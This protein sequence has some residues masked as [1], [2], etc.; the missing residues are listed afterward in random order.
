MFRF[1]DLITALSDKSKDSGLEFEAFDARGKE[2]D[3][4]DV[5][6]YMNKGVHEIGLYI[7]N[8]FIPGIRVYLTNT[9]MQ[10]DLARMPIKYGE[11]ISCFDETI[12]LGSFWNRTRY[13]VQD[14]VIPVQNLDP[15]ML[16]KYVVQIHPFANFDSPH[17]V[18]TVSDTIEMISICYPDMDKR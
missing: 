14:K 12:D 10:K 5:E 4:D 13:V 3:Y 6:S 1:K 17:L 15:L 7:V 16:S 8:D 18:T 9:E 11:F 2:V